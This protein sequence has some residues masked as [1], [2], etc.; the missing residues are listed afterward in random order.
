MENPQKKNQSKAQ[1]KG[2]PSSKQPAE[3]G[4][5]RPSSKRSS[6]CPSWC[7]PRQKTEPEEPVQAPQPVT[8][9]KAKA[10]TKPSIFRSLVP[11][12]WTEDQEG[13]W[14]LVCPPD[15]KDAE[16]KVWVKKSVENLNNTELMHFHWFL[17]SAEK[18][19]DGFA[20]IKRSRLQ[21]AG[22]LD[23]VDLMIQTYPTNYR[24][25]T[26][27]IMEK[28]SKNRQNEVFNWVMVNLD[29]L[30]DREL[31]YF[32]W[33][34]QT[35]DESKDGF[36]PIKKT[37]LKDGDRMDTADLMVQTYATDTK[38]VTKT[39]MK[40]I[41]S[42]KDN[43]LPEAEKQMKISSPAAAE[44]EELSKMLDQFV[45]KAP[46]ETLTQLSE[47]LVADGVLKSSEK[48][49]ILQKNHTRANKASCLA[50]TVMAK[51][52]G[53]CKKMID[54]LQTVD[55]PLSS[56]LGLLSGPSAQQG[57]TSQES[58]FKSIGEPGLAFQQFL[59]LAKKPLD[60]EKESWSQICPEGDNDADTKEWLKESL[61][62]LDSR[63]M[64]YFHWFLQTA[65][66]NKD[67]FKPIKKSR[68]EHAD[69]LD[70]VDLM[71]Q[72]YTTNTREVAEK[73]FRKLNKNIGHDLSYW[74]LDILDDLDDR[75]MKYFHWFLQSADKSKDGF[76]AIKK[77]QLEGAD[78]LDTVN[79]MVQTYAT[80]TKEV[81]EKI[82]EKIK[83]NK[84]N[85]VAEV[86]GQIPPS[87]PPAAEEEVLTRML[88]DFV[89]KVP[90]ETFN[91]LMEALIGSKALK[92][93]E[94]KEIL[95]NHT[96]VNMASCFVDIVT[97]KG[98]D[99]SKEVITRLQTIDPQLSTELS[100]P[101]SPGRKSRKKSSAVKKPRVMSKEQEDCWRQIC[102]PGDKDV[103][104]KLWLKRT[105]EDLKNKELKYFHWYLRMADESK[106]GFK[107]IRRYRLKYAGRLDTL[108]LLLQMYSAKAKE[109]TE[110]ILEKIRNNKAQHMLLDIFEEMGDMDLKYCQ[111]MLQ[112]T[113][114]F[115]SNM[116][117]IK[118]V[119][120]ENQEIVS[121]VGMMM[122]MYS[123][124]HREELARALNEIQESTENLC[125]DEDED[126]MSPEAIRERRIKNMLLE[127]IRK[128]SNETL[129]QLLK[130]LVADKVLTASESKAVVEKNRTRV[131]KASCLIDMV[132]E[133][134]CD[135]GQKLLNHLQ[136]IDAPLFS[137]LELTQPPPLQQ[138]LLELLG[139]KTKEEGKTKDGEKAEGDKTEEKGG[140]Q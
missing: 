10:D 19:V 53:A 127:F 131:N 79:L 41:M 23:T 87:S 62:D 83:S 24:K 135:A 107:P 101:S 42:S 132:K 13:I 6:A 40:K 82:V 114:K 65:D 109:V 68:L 118:R 44:E 77:S 102:P 81:T 78:R 9:A 112:N 103:V 89:E 126:S 97:E 106:D 30:D 122:H 57:N 32:H 49:N 48:E 128:V 34:L 4:P 115:M 22:R 94:K 26:E 125:E 67:G 56:K 88:N 16:S 51:G 71:V 74:L 123:A 110:K 91:Q 47:A 35:A 100:T 63:E 31:K 133:K 52:T 86:E 12:F 111:M 90:K 85:T 113:D 1:S 76:K 93:S 59:G 139:L 96:R 58:K 29:N 15:D 95:Q 27:K 72:M 66:K 64:K 137:E 104:L 14:P 45:K 55:A 116:P 117:S 7:W 121:S 108:D 138:E 8:E 84:D 134:G 37:R 136:A 119:S 43:G 129:E 3:A 36:K 39:I 17:Q 73:I 25:V 50:D 140:D 21:H 18:S 105:L 130:N 11:R 33:F 70:T 61:E 124:E 75:E 60:D 38:Q 54:H 46:K 28:I 69:R 2:G 92:S 5:S 80:N 99:T 120:V 98:A 20:P